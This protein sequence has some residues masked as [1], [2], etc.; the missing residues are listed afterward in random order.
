MVLK[1]AFY[2][3]K[4]WLNPVLFS[5]RY[6]ALGRTSNDKSW[7]RW[8]LPVPVT[9]EA[10]LGTVTLGEARAGDTTSQPRKPTPHRSICT[11]KENQSQG[12]G[13]RGGLFLWFQPCSSF[14]SDV[15]LHCQTVRFPLEHLFASLL[16]QFM[17]SRTAAKNVK[18]RCAICFK[19][20]FKTYVLTPK[21]TWRG[22]RQP[23]CCCRCL[24]HPFQ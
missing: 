19:S 12:T 4:I 14:A 20:V 6:I 11:T 16:L 13:D 24:L 8:R 7:Q 5:A 15:C 1:S 18:E 3:I 23:R 9:P 2:T 22:G 21:E 17:N 10:V